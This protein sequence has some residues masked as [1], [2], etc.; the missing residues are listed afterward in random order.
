MTIDDL[1]SEYIDLKRSLLSAH[2][3]DSYISIYNVHIHPRMGD[4]SLD[5]LNFSFYQKFLSKIC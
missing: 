1:F 5:G 3:V 2:V 4:L